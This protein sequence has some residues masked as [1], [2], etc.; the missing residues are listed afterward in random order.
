MVHLENISTVSPIAL[1]KL[2]DNFNIAKNLRDVFPYPYTLND[3]QIFI[4]LVKDNKVGH[5]FAIY[6][7]DTFIGMGGIVRQEDIYRNSAEIGYWLGEAFWGNGYATE[8]VKLLTRYAFD[9]LNLV[10]IY[11][12]VFAGNVP[13][14]KVLEKAGYRLE[15]ILQSS[16]TK[17]EKILDQHLYSI[18]AGPSG[19]AG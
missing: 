7:D 18:T 11:A 19:L 5:V 9:Q 16:V 8:A 17:H 6:N 3:A 1:Q 12:G 10:R 13:S 2:A 4:Q 15:A 14:M